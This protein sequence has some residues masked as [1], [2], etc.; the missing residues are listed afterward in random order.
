MR[1][2]PFAL[3]FACALQVSTAL[4]E[5]IVSQTGKNPALTL[6]SSGYGLVHET[7]LI[8]LGKGAH[9]ISLQDLPPTIRQ[10]SVLA[11]GD[12]LTIQKRLFDFG[13]I[14]PEAL[15][16][17]SLGKTI[18]VI[19]T[20]PQTGEEAEIEATVL[21]LRGG[22]IL[23]IGERIETGIPGRLAFKD[24]PEGL[25]AE[26]ALT[27]IAD[28][29]EAGPK[30]LGLTYIADGLDWNAAYVARINDAGTA[31]DLTGFAQL[32]NTTDRTY[33][34]AEIRVVAGEIRQPR[35]PRAMMMD[36]ETSRFGGLA[37]APAAKTE[38]LERQ[39]TGEQH[40][41][42]LPG[43]VTLQSHQTQQVTLLEADAIPAKTEYL[44]R[45]GVYRQ[46]LPKNDNAQRPEIRVSFK[47]DK[48]SGLGVP[49]PAGSIRTF[50]GE[51]AATLF[52]GE[53]FLSRK[54][55]GETAEL[56][57]GRAFDITL[58]RNQ[59]DFQV[60]DPKGHD[61]TFEAAWKL[62]LTNAHDKPV[63]VVIEESMSGAWEV[64]KESHSHKKD[65]TAT[66][67]WTVTLKPGG[68]E[69]LSYRVRVVPR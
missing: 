60:K 1:I 10:N 57:L 43:K 56:T 53:A 46:P 59:T 16:K 41:Y 42:R 9:E 64:L 19:K 21:S 37:A 48:A 30:T 20:N 11:S 12:G 50:K 7:R 28:S 34:D 38:S 31:L 6:Y 44:F 15:L 35:A 26:P 3:A 24:I 25:L 14:S 47:N 51:G 5:P 13:T 55:A 33:D 8:T 27:L 61:R 32:T 54:A 39:S 45:N 23:K 65:G 4:A 17:H 49:L 18:T 67:R 58:T 63:T 52:T 22:L 36:A 68:K 2:A 66:A 40:I 29:A 62:D 69:T